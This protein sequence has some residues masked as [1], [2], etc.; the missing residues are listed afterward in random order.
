MSREVVILIDSD[1]FREDEKREERIDALKRCSL[2]DTLGRRRYRAHSRFFFSLFVDSSC[3]MSRE[4]VILIDSDIFREDEKREE[5]IDAL[6]RCYAR[7]TQRYRAY[8]T[9]LDT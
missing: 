5:R 9:Y 4:V 8:S 7:P 6:K 1:I 2:R 3:V